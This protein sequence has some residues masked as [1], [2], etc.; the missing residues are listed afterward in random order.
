MAALTGLRGLLASVAQAIRAEDGASLANLLSLERVADLGT[1]V[2]AIQ[3]AHI[4][5][6]VYGVWNP[7]SNNGADKTWSKTMLSH[8]TA[9]GK[10]SEAGAAASSSSSSSAV[11]L[12]AL[13]AAFDAEHTALKEF[14]GLVADSQTNWVLRPLHTLVLGTWNLG[15]R[16]EAAFDANGQRDAATGRIVSFQWARR[17]CLFA[18]N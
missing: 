18:K 13:E 3:P 6:A 7:N 1:V 17:P 9:L 4:Q 8:L 2:Q 15:Q 14:L 16:L 11:L 5:T 10:A 12:A